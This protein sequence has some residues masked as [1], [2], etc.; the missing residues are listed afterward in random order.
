MTEPPG[1]EESTLSYKAKAGAF[2]AFA[3][4]FGLLA[5]FGGALSQVRL[6]SAPHGFERN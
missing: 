3:G 4:G 1:K 6:H 2:L 5:G